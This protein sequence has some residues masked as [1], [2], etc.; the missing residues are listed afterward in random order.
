MGEMVT[1]PGAA[2]KGLVAGAAVRLPPDLPGVCLGKS[3]PYGAG[4]T[5]GGYPYG[6]SRSASRRRYSSRSPWKVASTA[7]ER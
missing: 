7:G 6:A 2:G 4:V 3:M 1:P 5:A